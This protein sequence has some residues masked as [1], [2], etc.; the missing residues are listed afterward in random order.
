MKPTDKRDQVK[1][2]QGMGSTSGGGKS[3]NC[4]RLFFELLLSPNN[5][6]RKIRNYKVSPEEFERQLFYPLL[7]LTAV[8][9]FFQLIYEPST[10]IANILQKSIL[11]FV[12]IFSG[13]FAALGIARIILPPKASEKVS[14]HFFRVFIA[15][16]M[17]TL[18][19]GYLISLLAPQLDI[20]LWLGIIYTFYIVCRGVKYLHVPHKERFATSVLSCVLVFFLP[21]LIY[22]LLTYLMP[23][24]A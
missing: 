5:G 8:C 1:S 18:D 22:G 15:A 20:V 4:T 11:G 17:A 12:S 24:A 19:M 23:S 13:Y 14:T 16:S 2:D 7:A 9:Q 10:P 3:Y 6:W 21:S